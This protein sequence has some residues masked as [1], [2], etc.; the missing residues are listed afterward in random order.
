[1]L[2]EKTMEG[3]EIVSVSFGV[4][5]WWVATAYITLCK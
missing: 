1:M 4:N 5:I 2:N 3:W